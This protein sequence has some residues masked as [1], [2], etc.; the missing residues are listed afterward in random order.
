[1]EHKTE[2]KNKGMN[3]LSWIS[4]NGCNTNPFTN[5][6]K[7]PVASLILYTNDK[8]LGNQSVINL[9]YAIPYV[10]QPKAYINLP[11]SIT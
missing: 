9:N 11:V 4:A 5:T 10:S 3:K 7:E 6:E 2:Q 1:M 8:F